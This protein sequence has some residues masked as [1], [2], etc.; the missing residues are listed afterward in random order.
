[1][2]RTETPIINL[3]PTH[4]SVYTHEQAD[5][6]SKAYRKLGVA[7]LTLV[8]LVLRW[9]RNI[10]LEF[11]VG[12]STEETLGKKKQKKHTH[13]T[14]TPFIHRKSEST[15]KKCPHLAR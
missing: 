10:I 14:K 9:L 7:G 11:G 4:A 6:H 8:I 13:T 2:K 3:A 15:K 12:L 5:T 1:M